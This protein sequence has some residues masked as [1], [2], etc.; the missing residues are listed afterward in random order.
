VRG[1]ERLPW[2]RPA[3]HL[4]GR[5]AMAA[6]RLSDP[7]KQPAAQC[8]EEPDVGTV[9]AQDDRVW[10]KELV[11]ETARDAAHH[12]S[13][14]VTPLLVLGDRRGMGAKVS[15][16]GRA[17]ELSPVRRAQLTPPGRAW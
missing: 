11:P 17:G 1:C 6:Q 14:Q 5:L 3:G 4:R 12:P 7:R 9:P 8:V 15:P 13:C 10:A 16:G 2:A